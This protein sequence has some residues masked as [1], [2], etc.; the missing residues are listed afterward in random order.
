MAGSQRASCLAGPQPT[1]ADG[2]H[3]DGESFAKENLLIYSQEN[4]PGGMAQWVEALEC[5]PH[6]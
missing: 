2:S 1:L 5:R 3:G 6:D 4:H